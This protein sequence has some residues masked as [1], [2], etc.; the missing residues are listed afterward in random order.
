M[1]LKKLVGAVCALTIAVSAF[2]GLTVNAATGDVITVYSEN[3]DSLSS[4]AYESKTSDTEVSIKELSVVNTPISG[5]SLFIKGNK[6]TAVN[7]LG[8]NIPLMTNQDTV[9]PSVKLSSYDNVVVDFDVKVDQIRT[10]GKKATSYLELAD[11]NKT[12]LLHMTVGTG[13]NYGENTVKLSDGTSQEVNSSYMHIKMTCDFVEKT[14]NVVVT[15]SNNIELANI[16][17]VSKIPAVNFAGFYHANTEWSYGGCYIDNLNV[18]TID[19]GIE[20][21][22]VTVNYKCGDTVIADAKQQ[23]VVS[24]GSFTPEYLQKITTD[25]YIYTYASGGDTVTNITDDT[26]IN[27]EYTSQARTK[28]DFVV[29]AVNKGETIKKLYEQNNVPVDNT[30]IFA[31]PIYLT[32]ENGKIEY[33]LAD[34]SVCREEVIVDETGNYSVEYVATAENKYFFDSDALGSY[35]ATETRKDISN[36]T[37]GRLKANSSVQINTWTAPT[38]NKYSVTISARNQ[39]AAEETASYTFYEIKADGTEVSLGE[40]PTWSSVAAGGINQYVSKSADIQLSRGS[41]LA[42]KN[43]TT[44]NSNIFID[45]VLIQPIIST[46]YF[47]ATTA[48]GAAFSKVE[49]TASKG[50][51]ERIGF[52]NFDTIISGGGTIGI[53]ITD[54]PDGVTIKK[55]TLK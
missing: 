22:T 37:A 2:A 11:S 10:D 41:K 12:S 3:F 49:I 13:S 4:F 51:V 18:T 16:T 38:D 17:A 14:Q 15:D 35:A 44:S 45:Y 54:I 8:Y 53:A 34:T 6:S 46:N 43:T 24:G 25:D 36:G 19:K 9:S 52:K 5:K 30:V 1:K 27:I 55:V 40:T 20:S 48:A 32:D 47:T 29:N 21:Y 33:M 39:R 50:S 28:V 31:Y 7:Y 26:I 23:V 42:I